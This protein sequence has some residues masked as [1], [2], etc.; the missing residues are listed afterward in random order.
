M[1]NDNAYYWSLKIYIK[2]QAI[3]LAYLYVI[4]IVIIQYYKSNAFF[5]LVL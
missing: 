3:E 5:C 4:L 2:K 1:K